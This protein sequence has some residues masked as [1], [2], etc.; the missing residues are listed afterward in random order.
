VLVPIVEELCFHA[1]DNFLLTL[2]SGN[3]S[4]VLTNWFE[5]YFATP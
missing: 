3:V 5:H 2:I 1:A 4:L